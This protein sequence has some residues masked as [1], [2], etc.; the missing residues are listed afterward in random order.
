MLKY[1][2]ACAA[3]VSASVSA[4]A[5]LGSHFEIRNPKFEIL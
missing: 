4:S 2:C 3:L 5:A 1:V